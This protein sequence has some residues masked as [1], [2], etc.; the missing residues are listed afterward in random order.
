MYVLY[1]VW[2]III[3]KGSTPNGRCV[4]LRKSASGN[5]TLTGE[6]LGVAGRVYEYNA[7]AKELLTAGNGAVAM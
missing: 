7:F 6:R 1:F 5:D 3:L 4:H 2:K